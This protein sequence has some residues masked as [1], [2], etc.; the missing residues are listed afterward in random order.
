MTRF[1][2]GSMSVVLPSGKH[3]AAEVLHDTPSPMQRLRAGINGMS[4]DCDTYTRLLIDGRLWM[5]DAEFEYR[6]NIGVVVEARGDVLIAG[7]GIGFILPPI[8]ARKEVSSVTVLER[9]ADVIALVSPH[10][11]KVKVIH[12][13]AHQWE[14]P[15]RSFD[16]IYFDIWADV[17]NSDNL[18]EIKAL[19][20]RY[21]SAL[22][23]GGRTA[24]W[25][26]DHA[27]SRR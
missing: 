21:R 23:K 22:R 5:T 1:S 12:A 9:S 8:L 24:A 7:L 11:P 27:R 3:G 19:K 10:F 4:L 6:S 2:P 25:C 18:K 20:L 13:D 14:P 15:K 16:L 17:P 26:E